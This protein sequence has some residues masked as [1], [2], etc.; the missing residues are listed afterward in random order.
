VNGV[1]PNEHLTKLGASR[2]SYGPI[3]YIR[4]MGVLQQKAGKVLSYT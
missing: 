2:I 4:A 3:P 1:P